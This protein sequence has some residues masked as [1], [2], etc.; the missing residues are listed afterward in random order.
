M[1]WVL[2]F[3]VLQDTLVFSWC[4]VQWSVCVLLDLGGLWSLFR[5]SHMIYLAFRIVEIA[6]TKERREVK[7]YLCSQ[8]QL[9]ICHTRCGILSML[10]W[11]WTWAESGEEKPMLHALPNPWKL[12]VSDAFQT[13]MQSAGGGW[14]FFA[15][16]TLFPF[17]DG[18]W[19]KWENGQLAKTKHD[20]KIFY[21]SIP[22]RPLS[23]CHPITQTLRCS[24]WK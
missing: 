3:K 20:S 22:S 6:K 23:L 1:C 2:L 11:C 15:F 17:Q 18:E 21:R 19:R 12:R 16:W 14:N 4:W 5:V 24:W 9:Q 7:R 10:C 13:R 8:W